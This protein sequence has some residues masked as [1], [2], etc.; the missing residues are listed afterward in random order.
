[1]STVCLF[2]FSNFGIC[3]L[4][5]SFG[6]LMATWTE[7]ERMSWCVGSEN[8]SSTCS[9]PRVRLSCRYWPFGQDGCALHGFQGMISV[10]ASISFMAAI[11]WDRYHQYCT[12]EYNALPK[13]LD[14][15]EIHSLIWLP[16][17]LLQK[18][19]H[20]S[21]M[22]IYSL[23]WVSTDWIWESVRLSD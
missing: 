19:L 6:L 7:T 15:K 20:L 21:K 8:I 17:L 12:S 1:M 3:S 4:N 11:A 2:I 10:L 9:L 18:Q 23:R 22:L 14:I 13:Y 5:E 16:G